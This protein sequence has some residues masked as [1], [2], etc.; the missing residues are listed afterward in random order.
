[1]KM[2]ND[3]WMYSYIRKEM[4]DTWCY[5][6]QNYSDGDLNRCNECQGIMSDPLSP[7]KD[8]PPTKFKPII[9]EEKKMIITIIGS[10][11]NKESMNACKEYWERFGHKVNCPCDS[12]RDGMSLITKQSDWIKKIEES[13]LIVAI[14]KELS[15]EGNGGTKHILDFGESTTYEMAIALRFNKPIVFW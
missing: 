4:K 1:M 9:K 3:D 8:N 11:K 2:L 14:H 13:D 6:C 5:F 7:E 15:I 12:D 10:C